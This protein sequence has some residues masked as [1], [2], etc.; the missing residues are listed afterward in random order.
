MHPLQCF[1]CMENGKVTLL[2]QIICGFIYTSF[3]LYWF[4]GYLRKVK[5]IHDYDLRQVTLNEKLQK[6]E[7]KENVKYQSIFCHWRHN[8]IF[9]I[10]CYIKLQIILSYPALSSAFIGVSW[11]DNNNNKLIII[12]SPSLSKMGTNKKRKYA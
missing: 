7:H 2:C 4:S 9:W 10:A 11:D 3:C 8:T 6:S 5:M 12:I 1:G